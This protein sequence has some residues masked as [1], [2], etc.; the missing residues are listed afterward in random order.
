DFLGRGSHKTAT[1]ARLL[2]AETFTCQVDN[3]LVT[4]R[5]NAVDEMIQ[6]GL[7]HGVGRLQERVTRE[8]RFTPL[9]GVTHPRFAKRGLLAGDG[10]IALLMPE[11]SQ[12]AVGPPLMP[13]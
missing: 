3:L 4:P 11:S 7:G 9:V 6:S 5:R 2:H 12:L 10:H 1:D 8:L 13:L